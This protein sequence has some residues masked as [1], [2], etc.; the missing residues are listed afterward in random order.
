MGCMASAASVCIMIPMDTI[1]TRLVT[2]MS[3]KVIM[4]APYK[5]IIDCAVRVAQE[6]GIKAFYRGLPPRLI[7][8]VPMIG[9]QFGVYEAM[10]K[11][12]LRRSL[13]PEN[14]RRSEMMIDRYGPEQALEE[15]AM[16]VAA[17]SAQPLPAPHFLE[18]IEQI[19]KTKPEGL[20]G[21][22]FN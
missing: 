10:K 9:I 14:E 1:K 11:V 18:K 15:V 3:A 20:F 5:G 13:S 22:K 8:V 4:G 17:S 7:S 21:F 2:Q 6:E 16:E 19:V 12:M